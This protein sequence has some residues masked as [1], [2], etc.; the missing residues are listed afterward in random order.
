MTIQEVRSIAKTLG[1][2]TARM[3]KADIIRAIQAAEGNFDCYGSPADG[4]CD[5]EDCIW[6]EDCLTSAGA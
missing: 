5:Q 3:S 6:R 1:I 2:K 4:Y